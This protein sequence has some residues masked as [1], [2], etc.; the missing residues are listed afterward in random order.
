MTEP[1][2][3]E[4]KAYALRRIKAQNP[5]VQVD[6]WEEFLALEGV[7]LAVETIN[8]LLEGGMIPPDNE[9]AKSIAGTAE[10][11][12]AQTSAKS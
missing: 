1:I 9:Y 10:R 12:K 3:P 6:T 4:M 2:T 8:E 11:K 7:P 5:Q